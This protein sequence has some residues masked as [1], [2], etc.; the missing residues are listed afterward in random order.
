MY[1]F[2]HLLTIHKS[3]YLLKC[4]FVFEY[5]ISITSFRYNLI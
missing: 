3:N 4:P 5:F 1:V 2:S